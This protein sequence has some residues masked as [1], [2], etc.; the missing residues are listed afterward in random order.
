MGSLAPT[1]VPPGGL[2]LVT[3]VNGFLASHIALNLLERGYKVRGTVRSQEKADWITEAI[4]KRYPDASFETA[5]VPNISAPGA[6]NEAIR[7]VDGIAHVASDL[8]FGSD[9]NKVIA[10]MLEALRHILTSAAKEPS[11]KRF[12]LTSSAIAALTPQPEQAI[13]V[14]TNT[15]NDSSIERAWR[16]APYEPERCWDVY[17]A[18]KTSTERE[19]WRFSQENNPAFVVNA[20]LP[21][22]I[23][24][25]IIHARQNGSTGRW[26]K[27][28]FDDPVHYSK[29]LQTFIPRHFVDVTDVALLHL[30]GLTHEDV[31]SERLLAFAG[32]FNFNSWLHVFRQI[33]PAKPWPADDP[34]QVHDRSTVDTRRSKEL[35]KRYSRLD[36]TSFFDS[37]R[38][39]CLN[40]D[41]EWKRSNF[42]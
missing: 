34:N 38:D 33:D 5:L 9:P 37:V 4:A 7:G 22:F 1:I 35:L 8:S 21:D 12:V 40:S 39:N 11:V 30:A 14:D 26:V 18:L 17:A 23:V 42:P 31:Q 3:G 32:P 41:P 16:P 10:P 36:F 25:P 28:F 27:E 2:V 6:F 15:W 24:G 29:P 20:V 19:L 13:H